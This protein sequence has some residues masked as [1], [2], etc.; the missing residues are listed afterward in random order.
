MKL[1]KKAALGLLAAVVCI[2]A[3]GCGK[4][5][6]P[7]SD[8]PAG[9][10]DQAIVPGFNNPTP[11]PVSYT[12]VYASAFGDTV[13]LATV[14]VEEWHSLESDCPAREISNGG[15][16][17]CNGDHEDEV[18]ITKVIILEDLIPR[19]CSGWF[20]DMIHLEKIQ[21]IEMIHTHEVSDMSF[22]FAGCEKLEELDLSSWDISKVTDMTEMF[23]NCH[24]LDKLPDWYQ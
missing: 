14:P 4:Q 7:L 19:V 12:P 21:G 11:K 10:P 8:L 1:V 2:S 15:R 13:I 9:T 5:K 18:P 20:R 23:Q 6:Q 3:F 17:K 24:S 22:M 16:I